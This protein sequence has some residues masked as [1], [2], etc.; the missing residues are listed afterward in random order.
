MS[1]IYLIILF[2]SP[3]L[4]IYGGNEI[5]PPDD[6]LTEWGTALPEE[7]DGVRIFRV[8]GP[9]SKGNSGVNGLV[10]L[11]GIDREKAF[12]GAYVGVS[13]SLNNET[14]E[15]D[16]VD[17]DNMRFSVYRE[18]HDGTGKNAL[19]YRYRTAYQFT[20]EIMTFSSFDITIEFKEKGLI[21]RKLDVEKFKPSTN[22]R[23]REIVESFAIANSR[24]VNEVACHIKESKDANVT[25]WDGIKN[26]LVQKGMNETEVILIGGKPNI[27][28]PSGKRTQ[29]IYSNDFIVIFT[30]GVVTN[31]IQ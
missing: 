15:I 21:P 26:G 10:D 19:I 16:A 24:L 29:W 3:F 2:L 9:D 20:D 30:D 17:Y 31:V 25:H 28:S 18:V 7:V 1:R 14:D 23:H 11:P 4:E 13:E 5:A 8:S 6:E 27:V 12:V 22:N